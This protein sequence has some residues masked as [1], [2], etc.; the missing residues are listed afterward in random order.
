MVANLST[1]TQ[2][3]REG[4]CLLSSV[5]RTKNWNGEDVAS[6]IVN[7]FNNVSVSV[8]VGAGWNR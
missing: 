5:S 6:E 2:V 3:R 1:T 8:T 4:K 7:V